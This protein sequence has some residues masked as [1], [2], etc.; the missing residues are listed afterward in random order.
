MG[1]ACSYVWGDDEC[2]QN[3]GWE[4]LEKQGRVGSRAL[5]WLLGGSG[6]CPMADF[7]I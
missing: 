5:I 4:I 7:G 2:I 1:W 3:F 6:W